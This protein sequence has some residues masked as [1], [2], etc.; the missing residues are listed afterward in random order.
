[1]Q[2]K[3]EL[4]ENE[5]ENIVKLQPPA[6]MPPSFVDPSFFACTRPTKPSPASTNQIKSHR[7]IVPIPI[8][9]QPR[10]DVL[11]PIQ[12]PVHRA[13]H[14]RHPRV[15]SMHGLDPLGRRHDAGE[16]EARGVDA[17]LVDE[18]AEG[19][20]RGAARGEHGVAEEDGPVDV[21]V[22]M[23]FGGGVWVMDHRACMLPRKGYNRDTA[24]RA[25]Y[26]L[27][28]RDVMWELA[29]EELGKLL[30]RGLVA[31]DKDLACIM[32]V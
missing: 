27:P 22:C 9:P 15:R 26:P 23:V 21:G 32:P 7:P 31:L 25:A 19:G 24:G 20:Q 12:P 18:D 3:T 14:D 4:L 17:A 28:R 11:I 29:V 10:H 8:V 5:K 6:T 1:M 30:R 2:L 16:D 13:R